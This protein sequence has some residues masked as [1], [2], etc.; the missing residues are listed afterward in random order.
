MSSLKTG[1]EWTDKTWNPTTG[2]T[3]ISEGCRYCYAE[4]ITER[5]PGNFPN[6]FKLTIH[7]ERLQQPR[8]WRKPSRIFVNSMSDLFHEDVPLDFL[9][10]VFQVMRETPQHIYQILTKRHERLLELA[11]SLIWCPN[12]WMGVSVENQ[13][14][15]ERVDFLRKVPASVKFISCEP[16]LGALKL[17]LTGIDWVIV[18]GESGRNHR[19]IE[20][21]WVEGILQQ[22]QTNKVA[23]FFKQWGG[24]NP[25]SGGKLLNGEI[26]QEVPSEWEEHLANFSY[27]DKRRKRTV[28]K[29]LSSEKIQAVTNL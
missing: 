25:K 17:D 2:C 19:P 6:G 11:D 29:I 9:L 22:C 27:V 13:R 12:I 14:Y 8:H 24:L 20:K 26:W 16:L 18:G 7:E 28:Q 4:T 23:F 1:I 10:Q 21:E 5:F 15:V 3:K